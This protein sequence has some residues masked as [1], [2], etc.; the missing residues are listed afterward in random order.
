MRYAKQ[1]AA[2]ALASL[3]SQ[4]NAE[5]PAPVTFYTNVRVA[6]DVTGAPTEVQGDPEMPELLRSR[7]EQTVREWRFSPPLKSGNPVSGVTYLHLGACAIAQADGGLNLSVDYKGNGPGAINLS[8]IFPQYPMDAVRSG[9][10]ADL[11]VVY[12]VGTDGLA[13]LEEI[14]DVTKRRG[15]SRTRVFQATIQDWVSKLRFKPEELA[16]QPVATRMETPVQFE[17]DSSE[18]ARSLQKKQMEKSR[19]TP[20]CIAA[21]EKKVE[22]GFGTLAV[23]SPFAMLD[24]K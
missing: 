8:K 22:P 6:L 19:M 24:Q 17:L 13:T 21:M 10:S 9:V 23:D 12:T 20:E 7:I 4:A 5:A 15:K 18:S 14:K 2:L 1:F 3:G 16:G 11:V